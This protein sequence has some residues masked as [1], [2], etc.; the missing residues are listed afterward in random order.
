[1][2]ID[3]AYGTQ[4]LQFRRRVVCGQRRLDALGMLEQRFDPESPARPGGLAGGPLSAST[5]SGKAV[6]AG[7]ASPSDNTDGKRCG[8]RILYRE[9]RR[10]RKH[11]L[12][13][14]TPSSGSSGPVKRA[15][16][17]STAAVRPHA[18]GSIG[19]RGGCGSHRQDTWAFSVTER[20]LLGDTGAR[21]QTQRRR[22]RQRRY[23]LQHLRAQHEAS[24]SGAG[25]STDRANSCPGRLRLRPER[26]S[27]FACVSAVM[28]TGVAA[29]SDVAKPGGWD[30]VWGE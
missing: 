24:G 28:F 4:T 13:G 26:F 23:S 2:T 25:P 12:D 19:A 11:D 5:R 29:G 17:A 1:M 22:Q 9:D 15:S 20:P 8:G 16:R 14:R 3:T 10:A 21:V 6:A 30:V 18:I 7:T 27:T